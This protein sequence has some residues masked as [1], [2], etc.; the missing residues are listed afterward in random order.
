MSKMSLQRS[1][2]TTV[3]M[4]LSACLVCAGALWAE[5]AKSDEEPTKTQE[6]LHLAD[7]TWLA[8]T[9]S[10]RALGGEVEE[11]WSMPSGGSMIGMF[12][13]TAN[14]KTRVIE[15]MI[16]TETADGVVYRFK[17]YGTDYT[18]WEPAAPLT[19]D[20]VELSDK[21]AVFDSSVQVKPKRLI[22]RRNA[23]GGVTVTVEGIDEGRLD[24]FDVPMYPLR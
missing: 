6:P 19:F 4:L 21:K 22:Y 9:W 23:E 18:P 5:E 15:F 10:G 17:H 8:G 3:G 11:H 1:L 20:L 24:S 16:I 13:L 7:L 14:G 2:L 12:R